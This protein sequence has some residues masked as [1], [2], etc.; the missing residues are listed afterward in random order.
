MGAG[1][2]R[3]SIG[4]YWPW[5]ALLDAQAGIV[6]HDQERDHGFSEKKIACQLKSQRWQ[7][8]HRGIYATFT[9]TLPRRARQWAAVLWAGTGASAEPD[10][11]D[12]AC[13]SGTGGLS[14]RLLSL[15]ERR[16]A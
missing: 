4:A 5:E 6:R 10:V 9:G 7:L 8:I 16:V 14:K 12:G 11:K 13:G 15:W 2:K 1:E 3:K